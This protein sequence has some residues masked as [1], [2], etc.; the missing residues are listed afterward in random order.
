MSEALRRYKKG[1]FNRAEVVIQS[2]GS[3]V[4][5]LAEEGKKKVY[6]FRVKNLNQPNEEEV[7]IDTGKP[8]IK[9]NL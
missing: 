3:Q 7:D 4:F 5:T 6:K 2:D 1:K 9:R 8:I